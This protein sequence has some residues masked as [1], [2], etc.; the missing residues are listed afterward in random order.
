MAGGFAATVAA[1]AYGFHLDELQLAEP[2]WLA[3]PRE[4]GLALLGGAAMKLWQLTSQPQP[5][6]TIDPSAP[7][8]TTSE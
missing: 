2:H 5:P 3:I 8:D 6:P 7:P 4:G 1:R